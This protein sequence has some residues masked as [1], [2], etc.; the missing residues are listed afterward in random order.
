MGQHFS[1]GLASS[2]GIPPELSGQPRAAV[3]QALRGCLGR[4]GLRRCRKSGAS[5]HFTG[6]F[7]ANMQGLPSLG[8]TRRWQTAEAG[9]ASHGGRLFVNLLPEIY[10]QCSRVCSVTHSNLIKFLLD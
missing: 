6:T 3:N 7:H 1:R 2:R 8:K 5:P 9:L 4:W 10:A